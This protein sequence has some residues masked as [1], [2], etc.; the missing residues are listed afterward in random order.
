M[1]LRHVY[2]ALFVAGVI[3]PYAYFTPWFL[4]NGLNVRQFFAELF[5]NCVS[6]SFGMD[7]I[8]STAVLLIFATAETFR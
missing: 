3:A 8:V 7:I 4:S 1:K 2:F 6:A 5:V